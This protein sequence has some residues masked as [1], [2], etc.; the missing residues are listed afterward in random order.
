MTYYKVLYSKSAEKFIKQNRAVGIRF[1]KAFTEIANDILIVNNFDIKRYHHK[2]YD[3]IFRLR[4]GKYRAIFRI[5]KKIIINVID[6]GSRSGIYKR[7][8]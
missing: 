6:I 1:I 5:I 3:N 7:K 8:L 2:D 4:I